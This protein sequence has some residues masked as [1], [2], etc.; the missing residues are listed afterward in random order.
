MGG[1]EMRNGGS[2]EQLSLLGIEPAPP[3][4][5]RL[6]FA[7]FPDL[8][9]A[10]SIEAMAQQLRIEHRLTGHLLPSARLHVTLFH[11]GDFAAMPQAEIEA[12]G[13]AAA[14][15]KKPAVDIEFDRVGTF[16]GTGKLPLVLLA[17]DGASALTAFQRD[18]STALMKV[19]LA[20]RVAKAFTPHVTLMYSDRKVPTQPVDPVRWRASEFV[21]VHSLIGQGRYSRLGQW[22]LSG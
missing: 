21:L 16:S 13:K 15:L 8:A 17:G 19:G 7:F 20:H 18:L 11:V 3:V 10:S 5:D 14:S 9:A 2:S 6:F 1:S 12:A 22:P 4:R